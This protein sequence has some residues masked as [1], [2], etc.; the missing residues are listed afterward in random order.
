VLENALALEKKQR[1]AITQLKEYLITSLNKRF[2]VKIV[3]H[4]N[5]SPYIVSFIIHKGSSATILNG[6]SQQEV[7]VSTQSACASIE[8]PPS[9]VLLACGYTPQQAKAMIRVSFHYDT[10]KEEIDGFLAAYEKVEQY[11]Q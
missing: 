7:Y 8:N 11:V 9:H 10:T 1:Q 6:L 4:E 3:S 2:N 5:G